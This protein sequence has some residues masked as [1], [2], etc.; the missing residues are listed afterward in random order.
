MNTSSARHGPTCGRREG[1]VISDIVVLEAR[2]GENN[3]GLCLGGEVPGRVVGDSGERVAGQVVDRGGIN[4]DR[5]VRP[6]RERDRRIDGQCR[7][8]DGDLRVA[9]GNRDL[10]R[11]VEILDRDVAGADGDV[12]VE[13]H[14]Q[15]GAHR[16]IDR[17][18]ADRAIGRVQGAHRRVGG[19]GGRRGEA[20]VR[21]VGGKQ[22][23]VC[24]GG[25]VEVLDGITA[26]LDGVFFLANEVCRRV[27]GQH[28]PR[29]RHIARQRDRD[30]RPAGGK[31]LQGDAARSGQS[32][33]L[34]EGRHEIAEGRHLDGIVRRDHRSQG[35]E[36]R[37]TRG[38]GGRQGFG[39]DKSRQVWVR[40]PVQAVVVPAA[41]DHLERH[42][43]AEGVVAVL[44]DLRI[45]IQRNDPVAIA[46]N[47][48]HLHA[49]VEQRQQPL[50][51]IVEMVVGGEFRDGDP[52]VRCGGTRAGITQQ[53]R[54]GKHPAD[55]G[56]LPGV[57][58][59][60]VVAQQASAA[61]GVED[62]PSGITTVVDQLVV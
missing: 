56:D 28:R 38:V 47:V 62:A 2:V 57:V 29:D 31:V 11:G 21:S 15:V 12:L 40:L 33:G 20:P 45:L 9:H 19:I 8:G 7:P 16:H 6:R 61:A 17:G 24:V 58:R 4:L 22:A 35:V 42:V 36:G 46:M 49:G 30:V 37:R 10:R 43:S 32:D 13:G 39:D 51:R 27:D 55:R 59:R 5:V 48:E 53:V 25:G 23:G 54:R 18:H 52:V 50:D 41:G 14:H 3:R 44:G 26:D 34:A 1:T 60:P